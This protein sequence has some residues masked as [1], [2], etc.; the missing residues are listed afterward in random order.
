[1]ALGRAAARGALFTI[2]SGIVARGIGLVSTLVL[3]RF[4]APSAYGEVTVAAVLVMTASQLSTL[5]LGQYLIAT[6]SA[7]RSTAFHVTVFHLLAGV[8]AYAVLFVAERPLGLAFDA[9]GLLRFL[10]GLV[11]S[12]LLDR[13]SYVPERVL[14]RDLRFGRLSMART[15]GDLAYAAG[16]IVLALLGWGA[17]AIVAGNLL[18]SGV[19]SFAF[20]AGVERRAWLEPARITKHETRALFAFGAPMALGASAAFASRRWDNLLVAHFFGPGPT[21]AYNLAY[22]LADVPAIQVGEQ[23]GDVLLPSFAR[24]E[25]SRR[26]SA[27]LRSMALLG[28]VVF[29]L[30]VGLG[31]VAPSL[32]AVLFDARWVSIGPMLVLLSAL[33]VTRPVGWTVASYLQAS[34]R[35]KQILWLEL[36]KLGCLVGSICTLGRL[37]PLWT[38]AAVGVAFALHAIASLWVVAREDGV[39]LRRSVGCLLP[40]L[41]ACIPLVVAVLGVR[42]AGQMAGGLVPIG[43]L[44]LEIAAGTLGYLAGAWFFAR[45]SS[46]E[47]ASRLLDAVRTRREAV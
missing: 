2:G 41:A 3:A 34:G 39:P 31:A 26:A 44:A 36:V 16:S 10:P 11:L 35:P 15:L 30:A 23:I 37:S 17:M 13:V 33:S 21:G 45:E 28:L 38:C 7:P 40:P 20:V 22:N 46:A 6:P 12:A 5:G 29:P 43:E 42:A 27:L 9:P 8:L 4:L 1:V 24:L 25:P 18:R 14:V 32:V 19:R 47:L